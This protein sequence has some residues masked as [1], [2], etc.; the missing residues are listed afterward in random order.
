MENVHDLLESYDGEHQLDIVDVLQNPQQAEDARVL[1]TPTLVREM[2][3]PVRVLVGDLSNLNRVREALN[4]STPNHK[5]AP[6]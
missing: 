3:L 2:P 4:L 6:V 1:A 5:E